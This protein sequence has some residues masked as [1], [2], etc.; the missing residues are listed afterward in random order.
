MKSTIEKISS[1]ISAQ[2]G[3]DALR[4]LEDAC[5]EFLKNKGSIHEINEISE[6]SKTIGDDESFPK[7]STIKVQV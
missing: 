4:L 6:F 3:N 5:Q 1:E 2:E 7:L